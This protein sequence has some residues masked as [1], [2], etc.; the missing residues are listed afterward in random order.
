ML[1]KKQELIS[2][3]NQQL[4]AGRILDENIVSDLLTFL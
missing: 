4:A 1:K 3:Q 2:L